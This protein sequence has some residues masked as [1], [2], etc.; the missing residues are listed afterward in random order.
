MPGAACASGSTALTQPVGDQAAFAWLPSPFAKSRAEAEA[1]N[2]CVWE[3]CLETGGR[4]CHCSDHPR[5]QEFVQECMGVTEKKT[6]ESWVIRFQRDVLVRR[7]TRSDRCDTSTECSAWCHTLTIQPC[8]SAFAVGIMLESD[9]GRPTNQWEERDTIEEL[10]EWLR[11]LF[12]PSPMSFARDSAE[13]D[14]LPPMDH[15]DADWWDAP[16]VWEVPG[17]TAE[18]GGHGQCRAP[19]HPAAQVSPCADRVARRGKRAL[20]PSTPP[21]AVVS[22]AGCYAADRPKRARRAPTRLTCVELKDLGGSRALYNQ[23][24]RQVEAES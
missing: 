15:F 11:E 14:E 24:R 7:S 16:A 13:L 10:V 5:L 22:C 2:P 4:G 19:D 9:S 23:M 6:Q 17:G 18:P 20:S 21:G 12:W 1:G 3:S 8:G